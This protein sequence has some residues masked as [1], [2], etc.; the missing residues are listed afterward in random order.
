MNILG[1]EFDNQVG[2]PLIKMR[3]LAKTFQKDDHQIDALKSVSLE[4]HSGDFAVVLGSSGSG[5]S[6]FLNLVGCMESADA[7]E[8]IVGGQLV[9]GLKPQ[10]LAVVRK[11]KIGFVFQDH[12]L[13]SQ[14]TLLENVALPLLYR[15]ET[16]KRSME[17]A[18]QNLQSVGLSDRVS[19]YPSELSGGQK[20]RGSIAR[21]VTYNPPILLADEPTGALDSHTSKS[22]FELLK[23]QAERGR[24]VI[25]VT[26][27]DNTF[28]E[29]TRRLNIVDGWISE[30]SVQAA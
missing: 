23:T 21:A 4:F 16:R 6:T 28:S 3:D 5:K 9:T 17:L 11:S 10:E 24:V 14:Y 20:Q 25:V 30:T 18:M 12:N 22:I 15:G 13:L 19:H 2:Q 8:L 26:H 27:D 7:G 1:E 29:A